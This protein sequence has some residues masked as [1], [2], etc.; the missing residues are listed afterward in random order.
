MRKIARGEEMTKSLQQ[1]ARTHGLPR[2]LVTTATV[3][4]TT[5]GLSG[6]S[7]DFRALIQSAG[8]E[9]A[10]WVEISDEDLPTVISSGFESFTIAGTCSESGFALTLTSPVVQ[11]VICEASGTWSMTI[12]LSVLPDGTYAFHLQHTSTTGSVIEAISKDFVKISRIPSALQAPSLPNGYNNS[13]SIH[14]SWVAGLDSAGTVLMG[15][16]YSIGTTPGASDLVAWTALA[17]AGAADLSIPTSFSDSQNFF[18]NIRGVD[19]AGNRGDI[20]ISDPITVDTTAPVLGPLTA[21]ATVSPSLTTSP[22]FSWSAATDNT[23]GSGLSEYQYAIGLAAGDYSLRTWTT[24]AQ[25]T[26][27]SASGLNLAAGQ[28]YTISVRALDGAG[29]LSNIETATWSIPAATSGGGGTSNTPTLTGVTPSAGARLTP[30]QLTLTGTNFQAGAAVQ[31]GGQSCTGVLVSSATQLTC[32]APVSGTPGTVT[33]D[34]T[35]PDAGFASLSNGY[36]YL[37][38]PSIATVSPAGGPPAGGFSIT[39]TGTDLAATASTGAVTVGGAPCTVTASSGTSISCTTPPHAPGPYAL[40]VVN[41]DTQTATRID[42]VTYGPA[43]V[44]SSISPNSGLVDGGFPLTLSGVNFAVTSSGGSILVGGAPCPLTGTPSAT[45]LTCSAPARSAGAQAVTVVNPDLQSSTLTG[46]LTYGTGSGAGPAPVISSVT[47]STGS[48]LTTTSITISGSNIQSGATASIGTLPCGS[49]SVAADGTSMTC[50][51]PVANVSGPYS[52]T[53]VNPDLGMGA[54]TNA[55]TYLSSPSI[56][57][58]IPAGGPP[59]GGFTITINGA[60]LQASSSA[61]MISIGGAP[62]EITSNTATSIVCTAPPMDAA[63]YS[64]T[65]TNPDGMATTRPAAINYGPA[66]GISAVTPSSGHINGGFTILISGSNFRVTTTSGSVKVGGANCPITGVPTEEAISCVAPARSAGSQDVVVTNPDGQIA[67]LAASVLYQT[68]IPLTITGVT[69]TSGS[70]LSATPL[71]I[72][73]TGFVSGATANVGALT[74]ASVNVASATSL[75]CTAPAANTSGAMSVSI[76]QSGGALATRTNGFTYLSAPGISSLSPTGG[77][78]AGGFP[79]TLSGSDLMATPDLGSILIGG[80]PCTITASSS[81]STTC[82]APSLASG[83]YSAIITNPDGQT[84]TRASAIT[85]GPG[86]EIATVAPTTGN[87]AGGF[88][89]SITGLQLQVTSAE[90]SIRIGG[91]PCLITGTPTLNAITCTAPAKSAGQHDLVITNPDGQIATL[92]GAVTYLSGDPLHLTTVSPASGSRL[93]STQITLSGTGFQNGATVQIGSQSCAAVNVLSSTSLSCSVPTYMGIGSANVT[94]TNPDQQEAVKAAGYTYLSAPGISAVMPNHGKP[95]GGFEIALAGSDLFATEVSGTITVGG[96]NCPITASTPTEA[97]CLAPARTAGSYA[98]VISNPDGQSSTLAGGL[99]YDPAPTLSGVSPNDGYLVGGTVIT[100]TGTGF[101]TGASVK[102]GSRDCIGVTVTS[103]TTANCTTPEGASLGATSVTFTNEDTQAVVAAG[104]FTYTETASSSSTSTLTSSAPIA[105]IGPNASIALVAIPRNTDGSLVG[106]GKTLEVTS[107]ATVTWAGGAACR[108]PATGCQSMTD[109][110]NGSYSVRAGVTSG[111]AANITF[112]ARSAEAGGDVVFTQTASTNFDNANFTSPYGR[113]IT[114]A[115]TITATDNGLNLYINMTTATDAAEFQ[116]QNQT[117]GHVFAGSGRLT[118]PAQTTTVTARLYIRPAS[119]HLGTNAKVDV[120]ALGC[121]SNTNKSVNLT[122]GEGCSAQAYGSSGATITT[123]VGGSHGGAA[124]ANSTS[125]VG[126]TYGNLRDPSLPGMG[127]SSSLLTYNGGGVFRMIT[128]GACALTGGASI[129]AGAITT[130]AGGS[131]SMTC[132]SLDA[133]GF[134]G[135]IAAN[136]GASSSTSYSSGGGGRVALITSGG[137][138]SWTGLPFPNTSG[139]VT[140]FISK[141]QAHGGTHSAATNRGGAGTIYIKHSGTPNGALLLANDGID[142]SAANAGK[143]RLVGISGTIQSTPATGSQVASVSYDSVPA[144]GTSFVNAYAGQ[145]IR[146][147]TSYD[148]G[149]Q[150]D[151]SDDNLLTIQANDATSITTTQAI[152]NTSVTKRFRTIEVFDY[153]EITQ[154]TSVLTNSDIYVTSGS[155]S[156]PTNPS[157]TVLNGVIAGLT[158]AKTYSATKGISFDLQ[159][160]QSYNFSGSSLS[161]KNLTSSIT[162]SLTANA[163]EF[164]AGNITLSGSSVT[165]LTGATSTTA[166]TL[167]GTAA[168]TSPTGITVGKYDQQ[169]GTVSAIGGLTL[170][171]SATNSLSGGT[172]TT[173]SITGTNLTLSGGTITHETST[174]AIKRLEITLNGGFTLSGSGLIDAKGIG[175]PGQTLPDLEGGTGYIS[176]IASTWLNATTDYYCGG[177]HGGLGGGNLTNCHVAPTYDDFRNP[178]LPG[179][180]GGYTVSNTGGGVVRISA[181]GVCRL[182]G[183]GSIDASAPLSRAAGGSVL[184]NCGTIDSTG[185][186]GTIKANGATGGTSA[187]GPTYPGGGGRI[188]LIT[189]GPA[190]AWTGA[191]AIPGTSGQIETFTNVVQARGGTGVNGTAG[192]GTIFLKHS[193]MPNGALLIANGGAAASS[194]TDGS[195]LINGFSGLLTSTAAGGSRTVNINVQSTSGPSLAAGLPAGIVNAFRNAKVRLDTSYSNGT[196]HDWTDDSIMSISSHTATA[197]TTV[198]SLPSSLADTGDTFRTIEVLDYLDVLQG[199]SVLSNS[200]IYLTSG[201]LSS[202]SGSD[203]LLMKGFIASY[204]NNAGFKAPLGKFFDFELAGTAGYTIGGGT[205]AGRH[206]TVSTSGTVLA[207]NIN[208]GSGALTLNGSGALTLTGGITAGPVVVS[209]GTLTAPTGITAS[210]YQQTGGTVVANGGLSLTSG[211]SAALSAGNLT[212]NSITGQN[213][214]ISGGTLNHELHATTIKRLNISLAGNFTLSGTASIDVRGLGSPNQS[215]PDYATGTTYSTVNAA[216]WLNAGTD[217]YCGGSHGGLGAANTAYCQSGPTFDDFRNP[218]LPGGGGGY[219]TNNNGGGVV[220]ISATGSCRLADSSTIDASGRSDHYRGAGGT[221]Y[222]KCAG[223]DSSGYTGSIKANG[224]AGIQGAGGP[225]YP[226]GGGRIALITTGN[227][228][229]WTGALVFPNNK[230]TVDSL[231]AKVQA[232]SGASAIGY[233][234]AGTVF[235]KHSGTPNGALLL[236]NGGQSTLNDTDGKT[237]L[238]GLSGTLSATPASGSKI[239]NITPTSTPGVP[240]GLNNLYK[241]MRVRLNTGYSAGTPL[242]WSDDALLTIDSHTGTTITSLEVIPDSVAVQGNNFRTLEVLDYLEIAEGTTVQSNSDIYVTTGSLSG[243]GAADSL[244]LNGVLAPYSGGAATLVNGKSIDFDLAGGHGFNVGTATI[245]GRHLAISTSGTTFPIK[246]GPWS[247][248]SG[249]ITLTSSNTINITGGISASSISLI[250]TTLTGTLGVSTGNYSQTGGTVTLPSGITSTSSVALS[251]STAA[252]IT[253]AITATNLTVNGGMIKHEAQSAAATKRLNINLTGAFSISGTA[254]L[255][256]SALG[257]PPY[258]FPNINSGEGYSTTLASTVVSTSYCGGSHG[259]TGAGPTATCTVAPTYDDFRNPNLPG[260]SGPYTN[261]SGGGVIRLTATGSCSLSNTASILADANLASYSGAGGSIYVNCGSIDTIGYT[262]L[263]RANGAPGTSGSFAGGGGR[264]AIM[265]SGGT[266]AWTGNLKV[267]TTPTEVTTLTGIVKAEGGAGTGAGAASTASGGAGTIFLKH[268]GIPYGALLVSNGSKTSAGANDGKTVLIGLS[269]TLS[270]TPGASSRDAL[271]NVASTPGVPTGFTNAYRGMK[272]RLNTGY[273]HGTASDWTDDAVNTIASHTASQITASDS[274]TNATQG[275]SFRTLEILDHLEITSGTGVAT[276]SDIFVRNGSLSNQGAT[277]S[278]T[279]NGIISSNSNSAEIAALTKKIDYDLSGSSSFNLGS[280]PIAARN[281]TFTSTGSVTA[282]ALNLGSSG[283]LVVNST[284]TLTLSG[285]VTAASV[286]LT[287]G[288]LSTPSIAA[289]NVTL[290]SGTLTTNGITGQNLR[291]LGGIA[292]HEAQTNSNITNRF[293]VNLSGFFEI[294]GSGKIDTSGLGVPIYNFPNL[295]TGEGH[296]TNL[297]STYVTNVCGGSHGGSGAGTTAPCF[298]S[299]TYDD[300]RNPKLPGASGG[301]TNYLGGGVVRITAAGTCTLA[302]TAQVL[303]DGI[304]TTYSGAGGSIYL[305]C[306]NFVSTGFAGLIRANG[307]PG[308]SGSFAGGGGRIALISTGASGS[309]S[310]ALQV[311]TNSTLVGNLLAL[312]QA[313]GGTVSGAGVGSLAPGGAGTLYLQAADLPNGALLLANGNKNTG[314]NNSGKTHLRGVAGTIAYTP[315]SGD[316]V[317][318][319]NVA[320]SNQYS[321]AWTNHYAGQKI[322]L[323]TGYTGGIGTPWNGDIFTLT[324]NTVTGGEN[325]LSV[326]RTISNTAA[327]NPFRTLEVLDYLELQPGVSVIS[328]SDLYITQGTLSDPNNATTM[329]FYGV[330]AQ[331]PNS[332][333]GFTNALG[334]GFEYE[335][336]GA[337]GYPSDLLGVSANSL[338]VNLT[339]GASIGLASV[340]LGTAGD[341]TIQAGTLNVSGAIQARSLAVSGA[342]LS[343][344]A[345]NL[346]SGNLTASG[347]STLTIPSITMGGGDITLSSSGTH[348]LGALSGARHFSM[349]AGKVQHAAQ[350][351]GVNVGVRRLDFSLSGNFDLSG[352]S[353]DVSGLG[354]PAWNT[355]GYIYHSNPT[356]ITEGSRTNATASV[357]GGSHGG[358]GGSVAAGSVAFDVYDDYR[359]PALPG[360]GAVSNATGAAGGGVIRIS[361]PSGAC[362]LANGATIK[363]NGTNYGGAGGTINLTCATLVAANTWTPS[364]AIQA[365]GGAGYTSVRGGGGGGRIALKTT[366]NAASWGNTLPYP[367]SNAALTTFKTYVKALGGT[368]GT[369]AQPGGAGTIYIKNGDSTHGDLII[370]NGTNSGVSAFAGRTELVSTAVNASVLNAVP[371]SSEATIAATGTPLLNRNRALSGYLLQFFTFDAANFNPSANTRTT[372]LIGTNGDN[373]FVAAPFYNFTGAAGKTY[374]FLY[375]LDSLEVGGNAQVDFAAAD[376]ILSNCDIHSN[377]GATFD[378]PVGSAIVGINAMYSASCSVPLAQR[379]A[380]VTYST[381][382]LPAGVPN[383]YF[384]Q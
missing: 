218:N 76:A 268:S 25:T 246:T 81:T 291:I 263:I 343:A 249:N 301:F 180:G 326:N 286:S 89:V 188:A 160:T 105:P 252:L 298:V 277:D 223:I 54:R 26:A 233:A 114:A 372:V 159:G 11:E 80:F 205:L 202:A 30:V 152:T 19:I 266:G 77:P 323:N 103:P 166:L 56:T 177:S 113:T 334:K 350:P 169:G 368:I 259:G 213:L 238:L 58:I 34:I 367:S 14:L 335:L 184:L 269:G 267:P 86:P 75:T 174:A 130:G 370:D 118:H 116:A 176:T 371:N 256:V 28:S 172:L 53:V 240:A 379:A 36:R 3:L 254:R 115:G 362:T 78:I 365:N 43:P 67:T 41:P 109:N 275:N 237:V 111:A 144:I 217:Y 264:I 280:G 7:K 57:G 178:N 211:G 196:P 153:L 90:G 348:T 147:D 222:L 73:G 50:I 241:G 340:N 27:I 91:S 85:Y 333:A 224:C 206:L 38:I 79:V 208:L 262:G 66:P 296:S 157:A 381:T 42:A 51:V 23:G 360:S 71:T 337:Y 247:F 165:T 10:P 299:P 186:T 9:L 189:S 300:F 356:L 40:Q 87:I 123:F 199:G 168:L 70:R 142:G 344:G 303:A 328:N 17:G 29:N 332:G 112:S 148:G 121:Q 39:F 128:S 285:G 279:L 382:G 327:T 354:F 164:S 305:N 134:T 62:C 361:A 315:G 338:T 181:M 131:I 375:Q 251:G 21:S 297:A 102:V 341:L 284:G 108:T 136:G 37:T 308:T 100:L 363:A 245:S 221:V 120:K 140:A 194:S 197:I 129:D 257:A 253:S 376:L 336:T 324:G 182:A 353:F 304:Q 250:N 190:S 216:T 287:T 98:V 187:S 99:R 352:G 110:G 139:S 290:N 171:G 293:E 330:L 355:Y 145:K 137:A 46:A 195:T 122:T 154:G 276:N 313:Y 49:P 321:A 380:R 192:A 173:N 183:T 92:P 226:G 167:S 74:C 258:N 212:A 33:V 88:T 302:N 261:Y 329:K 1:S 310:G 214:T 228:T 193:G 48:R 133:T 149:I 83:T 170:T 230:A 32:T 127:S 234:G 119:F 271:V 220:R 143:T 374:R 59:E 132:G 239:A 191:L 107:S 126:D 312:V 349:S 45:T 317:V 384:F 322:R 294:S 198:E 55:F 207:G 72:T 5:I 273:D 366:G 60:D 200:D 236:S 288:S 210:S 84:A 146:L 101:L 35:N 320:T 255:D 232:R 104:A 52:V 292:K 364:G 201:S 179:A 44:I 138:T 156:N 158:G 316:T 345:L 351:A 203:S 151:W 347:T 373:T 377:D 235:I 331:A 311:P 309:W 6:C 69:P 4:L 227:S 82:L 64:L 63:V 22:T 318:K 281:F 47:P 117:L 155:L 185:Y 163:L 243:Q 135:S 175:A 65:L 270:T 231:L 95:S 358:K 325:F 2:E 18:I 248:A 306:G 369:P 278:L 359:D 106:P 272:I 209:S 295:A 289:T 161:G 215:I 219:T 93:A 383:G 15:Y 162:G 229:T 307:G 260:S 68:V 378:V 13:G 150:G 96:A 16:E 342:G 12:D 31:V 357:N 8:I 242:N 339:T 319:V 265:T 283:N 124:G 244:T 225:S 282:G 125:I 94:V 61:G 346:S 20:T 204:T 24:N 274:I 141:V 314:D 97:R